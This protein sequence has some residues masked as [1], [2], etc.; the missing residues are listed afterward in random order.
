[1]S[2]KYGNVVMGI[3]PPNVDIPEDKE[4]ELI[5][6]ALAFFI[7]DTP[8]VIGG[9]GPFLAEKVVD[10]CKIDNP[11]EKDRFEVKFHL[12]TQIHDER[13]QRHPQIIA[14]YRIDRTRFACG[15]LLHALIP[16]TFGD[17]CLGINRYTGKAV[18]GLFFG[19]CPSVED[20]KALHH[21]IKRINREVAEFVDDVEHLQ[22]SIGY[23]A[24]ILHKMSDKT[25]KE[26][27]V[28]QPMIYFVNALHDLL[29]T[30]DTQKQK[31]KKTI[32]TKRKRRA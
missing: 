25:Y 13:E 8:I 9:V 4:G 18:E 24:H 20:V 29:Y 11:T 31:D 15:L 1:M 5:R 30:Q 22:R 6:K 7:Y 19:K 32:G 3:L 21:D 28:H 2:D 23:A 12:N 17:N 26:M 10:F 27:T 16:M 14:C